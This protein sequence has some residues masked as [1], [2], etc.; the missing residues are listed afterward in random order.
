MASEVVELEGHIVDSLTLAKVLDVI[1][2]AGADYRIVEFEVGRTNVDASRARIEII[3]DDEQRLASLLEEL[4]VHG[5]N[6]L[7]TADAQLVPCHS[8]AAFHA[9]FIS[10]HI[11]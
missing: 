1:L 6:R 3:D 2:G 4:Q 11:L 7:D 8:A 5:A 10:T 9:D